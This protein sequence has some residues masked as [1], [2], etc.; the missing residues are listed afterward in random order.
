MGAVCCSSL[1]WEQFIFRFFTVGL[2]LLWRRT[3]TRREARVGIV[4]AVGGGGTCR[5]WAGQ[6]ESL[7]ISPAD[8]HMP[9]P[10]SH[11]EPSS[12]G[13]GKL[14][15][16]TE[17]DGYLVFSES[18]S[19]ASV[20]R[21]RM[22]DPEGGEVPCRLQPHHSRDQDV[23]EDPSSSESCARQ[24]CTCTRSASDRSEPDVPRPW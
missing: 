10:F 9:F 23:D 19:R 6:I 24:R 17:S 16:Q 5:A 15:N 2:V 20:W 12:S 21:L 13:P 7:L 22:Y 1:A 4:W 3:R 18:T 14:R 8:G 11:A